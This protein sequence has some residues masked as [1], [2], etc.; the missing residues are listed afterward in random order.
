LKAGD[1]D[2][3]GDTDFATATSADGKIAWHE[4]L[5]GGPP[6]FETRMIAD[7][8]RNAMYVEIADLS[9]DG[10]PD[11]IASFA[12]W[13]DAYP[14]MAAWYENSGGLHPQF[15]PHLIAEGMTLTW[16]IVPLDLDRDGDMDFFI[17]DYQAGDNNDR[18]F[19]YENNGQRPPTFTRCYFRTVWRPRTMIPADLDNDSDQDLLLL[20]PNTLYAGRGVAWY[21]NLTNPS[22]RVPER[23][24]R[25][26]R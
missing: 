11:I 18:I 7:H 17:M 24:W 15:T 13:D 20:Y 16:R 10:K 23:V 19:Y 8:Y 3:D 6:V 9:N 2:G 5:G 14:S 21:Q 4:N 25:R 26:F 1:I 12:R 22:T